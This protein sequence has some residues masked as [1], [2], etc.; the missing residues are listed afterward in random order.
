MCRRNAV[1]GAGAAEYN[2]T[3]KRTSVFIQVS[4]SL[5]VF[6]LRFYRTNLQRARCWTPGGLQSKRE[7]FIFYYFFFFHHELLTP[8]VCEFCRICENSWQLF[9]QLKCFFFFDDF[10]SPKFSSRIIESSA[11]NSKH[12]MFSRSTLNIYRDIETYRMYIESFC[13]ITL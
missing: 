2:R 6:P 5:C 7:V 8:T 1:T 13:N 3:T 9:K 4:S 12:I 11:R 10:S